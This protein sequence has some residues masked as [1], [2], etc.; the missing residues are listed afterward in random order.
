M[1]WDRVLP[2]A[3]PE[4]MG[5]REVTAVTAD[6]R[7][8]TPGTLF[9]ALGGGR[10]DG[11]DYVTEAAQRGAIGVVSE[12]APTERAGLPWAVHP[13]A[14]QL[15][16]EAAARLRDCPGRDLTVVGVTGT[17]GKTTVAW[18]VGALLADEPGEAA[19]MGTLGW[20]APGSLASTDHTTPDAEVLQHRLAVLRDA[21]MR[22][23]AMEVS[24]HALDQKRLAGTPVD[25][26]VWTNLSPEHLDY[27][28]DLASYRAA[29]A[30]LFARPELGFAVLNAD[31]PA[32]SAVA[33]EIAPGTRVVRYGR[34]NGEVS[35]HSL[36]LGADGIRL[37]AETPVGRAR[38]SSPLVG[39]VNVANLLA[40][41]AVGVALGLDAETIGRRLSRAGAV[42][43]R[44]EL[45]G[46]T[47][48][49]A[50]V[51]VD[52][53]HTAE[54]L[55]R[56]LASAR[57]LVTGELWCVFGCGGE[58]DREKRPEMGRAADRRCD[59][60]VLTNDN[61]RGEAPEAILAAVRAG[62]ERLEPAVIPDR[63]TAIR[64]ALQ[65]AERGAAVVIAGKGHE[66][67][68]EVAGE[69][70]AFSDREVVREWLRTAGREAG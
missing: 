41:V 23:V 66:T 25:G 5:S 55:E 6:S 42:P 38:L 10:V 9:F 16:G 4:G 26:A 12:R 39:E 47:P 1:R 40:A 54:A 33:R 53:A 8:V 11:A 67:E 48:V 35:V 37:E 22:G 27:H 32:C 34:E 30:R 29:K 58:R 15:L 69:T 62:M 3:V 51:W 24:S 21:G 7:Q 14:R 44:M 52:Y 61:P 18:L 13:D 28:G 31:D 70:L 43:G 57:R 59:R 56:S 60:V 46:T 20:G 49:G 36:R 17:N 63:G 50:R 64:H 68:Q 45:L 19:I 65:S 2:E